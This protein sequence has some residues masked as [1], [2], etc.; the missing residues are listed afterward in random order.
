MIRKILFISALFAVTSMNAQNIEFGVKGG[1]NFSNESGNGTIEN[2]VGSDS[3]KMKTGFHVGAVANYRINPK[4]GVEADLMYSMQGYKDKVTVDA[5]Q[6]IND[7]NFNVTSHYIN[8]PIAAKFY[9]IDNFYVEC[10]PQMGYLLSK[11]GKLDNWDNENLFKSDANKK[12]DFG[13]FGGLGYE[14][15]NGFLVEA[16]YVH[17]LT[18]T[19][20]NI[21]G[22][23]NRNVQISIGYLF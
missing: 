14:F 11:K 15:D 1:I 7:E 23:K 19:M 10:G 20:K 8:L 12:F 13:I 3:H 17:G 9:P 22:H 16:R 18:E 4:F 6:I 2:Y 21:D 5:E